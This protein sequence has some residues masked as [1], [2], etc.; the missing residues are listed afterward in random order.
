MLVATKHDCTWIPGSNC[1]LVDIGLC[2]GRRRRRRKG[3]RKRLTAKARSHYHHH[4]VMYSCSH[5]VHTHTRKPRRS[6]TTT[7]RETIMAL[8]N[9]SD[10]G[11]H[12]RAETHHHHL[13]PDR[14]D[15]S[16]LDFMRYIRTYYYKLTKRL[17]GTAHAYC[18]QNMPID[19]C[20]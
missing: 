16:V 10:R 15:A 14:T 4:H 9:P 20:S 6:T 13:Q 1:R 8:S 12:C 3:G 19:I 2:W 18:V 5:I 11:K 17:Q 7:V